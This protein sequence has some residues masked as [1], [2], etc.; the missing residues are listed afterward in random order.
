VP[1]IYLNVHTYSS[2]V[3]VLYLKYTHHWSALYY[4]LERGVSDAQMIF[5]KSTFKNKLDENPALQYIHVT[6]TVLK[7]QNMA[8]SFMTYCNV[9]KD[10]A[11]EIEFLN[12]DVVSLAGRPNRG[13]MTVNRIGDLLPMPGRL[14]E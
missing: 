3:N 14:E 11:F 10:K 9:L 1:G 13:S 8:T 2:I 5:A 12:Y 4:L 6:T 7:Y